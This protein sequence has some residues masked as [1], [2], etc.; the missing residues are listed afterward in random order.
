MILNY[1]FFLSLVGTAS[2]YWIIPN[3]RT[4]NIFLSVAS[5]LFIAYYDLHAAIIVIVTSINT[6]YFAE[7]IQTKQN[8]AFYHTL[9]ISILVLLLI[10]LKYLGFLS[11]TINGITNFIHGFP[12]INFNY[13]LLPL[14]S[15]YII[16]KQISYLTDVYWKITDRGRFDEFILYTSLFTIYTAGPIERFERLKP[17]LGTTGKKF[18]PGYIEF[19][20]ERIVLGIFK[21][22]VIADWLGYFIDP[23]WQYQD[24]YSF[25][26]RTLA[27]FGYSIQIYMDFAGYSDIAIGSS[28]LFGLTIM[29]NFKWP[30]IQPNISQFWRSWHISL[31]E[32][33]RDYVFFPLS[34]LSENESWRM[35]FVPLIAMALC[36]LWHGPAWHFALWGI[37][38]GAGISFLQYWNLLKRRNPGLMKITKQRWFSASGTVFTFL[39]VTTGWLLFR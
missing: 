11:G 2:I 30:Y 1:Q 39:F 4:R 26:M 18:S 6:F 24:R 7:R 36:G 9:G 17:Q 19:A 34:K 33:I 15:S 3:Q 8:K 27:L 21:K 38:H 25:Q 31:S 12:V 10:I 14:G 35:L 23:I 13:L 22:A 28:K 29:E 20:F 5:L 37:W 16:F 32:W